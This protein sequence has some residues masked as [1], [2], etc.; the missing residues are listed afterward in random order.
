MPTFSNVMTGNLGIGEQFLL[1]ALRRRRL[2]GDA[3]APPLV[4]GFLLACGVSG[5]EAA[6]RSFEALWTVLHGDHGRQ[7]AVCPLRCALVSCDEANCLNLIA[8]A[9]HGTHCRLAQ[10][11]EALVGTGR[12]SELCAAAVDL[13]DILARAGH[14]LTPVPLQRPPLRVLH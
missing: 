11:A 2:D 13:A 4:H 6:L 3:T 1:W 9:Q 8:F 5:V 10:V 12:V 7:P 14:G